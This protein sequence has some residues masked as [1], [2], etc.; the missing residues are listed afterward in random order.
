MG[1]A[2]VVYCTAPHKHLPVII[3]LPFFQASDVTRCIA[4]RLHLKVLRER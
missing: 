2:A 3:G 4:G 1:A